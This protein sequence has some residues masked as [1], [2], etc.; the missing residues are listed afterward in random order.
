MRAA[1]TI[2]LALLIDMFMHPPRCWGADDK[3]PA[4]A[5]P[6]P[7]ALKV[8]PDMKGGDLVRHSALRTCRM[9]HRTPSSFGG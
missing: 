3:R 9:F 7:D 4:G 8:T 1:P 5:D 6:L 2:P